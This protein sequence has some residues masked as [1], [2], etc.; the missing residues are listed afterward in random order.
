MTLPDLTFRD[1][2][3]RLV[4]DRSPLAVGLD[5]SYEML[6]SWGLP[7]TPEG[8]RRACNIVL[9]AVGDRIAVVKPQV[10]FFE[11]FGPPGMAVL[12]EITDR[13]RSTGTMVVMDCKRGDIGSTMEAYG[14]A[15]LDEDGYGADGMTVCAYLGFGTVTPVLDLATRLGACV[16][17]V[18][19]SSNPEGI[20]LQSSRCEDGHTVAER[21]ALEIADYNRSRP[22]T[23]GSGAAG[24][25]VGATCGQR[26]HEVI[27]LLDGCPI[28]APGIG[29]QG[30][31]FASLQI[32]RGILRHG[33]D[34]ASLREIVERFRSEAWTAVI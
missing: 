4:P 26:A 16:F 27:E 32:S 13:C 2:L 28:L 25:V 22:A 14:H 15:F 12:R 5:P 21:L 1:R 30:A 20:A 7:T 6:A 8:L 34:V 33:P 9:D 3:A 23:I 24:A 11:R 19:M 10:G 29:A 17:V 31:T 18:V